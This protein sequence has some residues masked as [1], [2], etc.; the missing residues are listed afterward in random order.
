[1]DCG[2]YVPPQFTLA[3]SAGLWQ[4]WFFTGRNTK[5]VLCPEGWSRCAYWPGDLHNIC[6]AGDF[7]GID[8]SQTLAIHLFFSEPIFVYLTMSFDVVMSDL[9]LA[10]FFPQGG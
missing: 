2:V 1:M 5:P 7:P 9:Y 4:G 10:C 3:V 6:V 8:P